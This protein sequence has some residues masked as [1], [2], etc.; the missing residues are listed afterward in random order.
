MAEAPFA[1]G[2]AYIEAENGK[3]CQEM[4]LP[5]H[6][7]G[8]I[9][10]WPGPPGVRTLSRGAGAMSAKKGLLKWLGAFIAFDMAVLA[11][12]LVPDW[13]W[14]PVEPRV[15]VN[16]LT[17]VLCPPMLY[18]VTSILPAELK[19]VLVFW[20]TK[21][22]LPGYWAFSSH[23]GA[24]SRID[25][26]A[27]VAR[28]GP[29]PSEP[30]AQQRLWYKIYREHRGE[31]SVLDANRRFLTF[32]DLA[33]VSFLVAV[34]APITLW[35]FGFGF[36]GGAVAAVFA[37]QYLGACLAARSAGVRLV[38]TV[39]AIDGAQITPAPSASG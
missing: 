36:A 37:V 10:W 29:L 6:V 5:T 7:P 28:R 21:Y 14:G 12:A 23:M 8:I 17:T 39:L 18:L 3:V 22:P 13:R 34:L 1:G 27:V 31:E 9:R 15:I 30:E 4:G 26:D 25:P 16:A 11:V 2:E 32:R 33:T 24:D 20:R 35:L 19:A 38:R